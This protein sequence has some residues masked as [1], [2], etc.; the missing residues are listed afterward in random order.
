MEELRKKYEKRLRRIR[1]SRKEEEEEKE[2]RSKKTTKKVKIRKMLLTSA[3]RPS[4]SNEWLGRSLERRPYRTRTLSRGGAPREVCARQQLSGT[5][6]T[7]PLQ[8]YFINELGVRQIVRQYRVIE[9]K[10]IFTALS[11]ISRAIIQ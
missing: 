1:R 8:P 4:G 11:A 5:D 10:Y 7:P 3:P 9:L 6:G 2:K